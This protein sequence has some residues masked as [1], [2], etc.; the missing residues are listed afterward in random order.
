MDEIAD[1]R[2]L[3]EDKLKAADEKAERG[4]AAIREAMLEYLTAVKWY[5]AGEVEIDRPFSVEI[6][7]ETETTSVDYIIAVNGRRLLAIKCSPGALESRERHLIAF[8]RVVDPVMI[9]FA[10]VTDG[11]RGRLLDVSTGKVISEGLDSIPDKP[12]AVDLVA[13]LPM[14]PCP[15]ERLEREKR[16]L[17]AFDAIRCTEESPQ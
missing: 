12:H 7:G 6:G 9:P 8:A 2:K 17:L 13:A 14:A 11:M 5:S 1:R 3:I 4:L 16:V 15:A 10:M